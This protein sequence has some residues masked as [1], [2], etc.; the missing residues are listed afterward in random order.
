MTGFIGM[1]TS[2]VKVSLTETGCEKYL[3]ITIMDDQKSK[4]GKTRKN[5]FLRNSLVGLITGNSNAPDI[6]KKSSE[7]GEQMT[8]KKACTLL[9]FIP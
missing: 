7:L 9:V 3:Y 4:G 1:E 6:A 8:D 5:L 2:A